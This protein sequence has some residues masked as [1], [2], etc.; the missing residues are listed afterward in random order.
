[1]YVQ[2]SSLC[3]ESEIMQRWG[4]GVS[5]GKMLHIKLGKGDGPI[6]VTALWL[7]VQSLCEFE[8]RSLKKIESHV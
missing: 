5:F 8:D 7:N 2:V 3:I 1:M 4:G 6:E